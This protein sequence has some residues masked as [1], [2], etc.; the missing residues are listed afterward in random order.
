MTLVSTSDS[1]WSNCTP[2]DCL[3]SIYVQKHF[4]QESSF[5]SLGSGVVMS[6]IYFGILSNFLYTS[7]LSA[8]VD[9]TQ[10]LWLT[11][12]LIF[13][14]IYIPF[15][16]EFFFMSSVIQCLHRLFVSLF[17][18]VFCHLHFFRVCHENGSTF[19]NYLDGSFWSC[20]ICWFKISLTVYHFAFY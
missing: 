6:S 11:N 20:F 18:V 16:N 9:W 13:H 15:S 3:C 17:S 7:L 14:V 2:S 19:L 5:S 8:S 12:L 4:K 10:F 1:H